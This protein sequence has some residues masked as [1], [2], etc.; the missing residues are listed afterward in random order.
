MQTRTVASA[1]NLRHDS[2]GRDAVPPPSHPEWSSHPQ[3]GSYCGAPTSSNILFTTSQS[4]HQ[5]NAKQLK[6]GATCKETPCQLFAQ[7]D[8]CSSVSEVYSIICDEKADREQVIRIRD[9][10]ENIKGLEQGFKDEDFQDFYN[11]VEI[12]GSAMIDDMEIE[13]ISALSVFSNSMFLDGG[14]CTRECDIHEIGSDSDSGSNDPM[15]VDDTSCQ[16]PMD[17]EIEESRSQPGKGHHSRSPWFHMD[18]RTP[19]THDAPCMMVAQEQGLMCFQAIEFEQVSEEPGLQ[20]GYG[21]AIVSGYRSRVQL[22]V[23]DPVLDT[24]LEV[25][26]Y[27]IMIRHPIRADTDMTC[28]FFR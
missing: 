22:W 1:F 6:V 12:E 24:K 27:Y 20:H 13:E 4:L 25:T 8:T 7:G 10:V 19:H 16:H 9:S 28:K 3:R 5:R 26:T 18:F 15:V 11:Q 21:G 2:R 23:C 17:L 14:D